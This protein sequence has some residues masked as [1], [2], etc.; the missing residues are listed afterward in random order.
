MIPVLQNSLQELARASPFVALEPEEDLRLVRKVLV[1]GAYAHA[2]AGCDTRCGEPGRAVAPQNL[3]SRVENSGDK[4]V[5]PR[6]LRL[7]S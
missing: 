6:L 1:E 2:S 7:L 4:G 5:R 3:N